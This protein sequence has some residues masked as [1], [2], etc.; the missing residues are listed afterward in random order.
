[1]SQLE[2]VLTG[3]LPKQRWYAAKGGVL[4]TVRAEKVTT[5]REGDPRLDLYVVE[6]QGDRYQVPLSFRREQSEPL[7]YALVGEVGGW[8]CY[9]APHDA[10]V[11]A[12]W[13]RLIGER[14]TVGGVTFDGEIADGDMPG[15]PMGAEQSNTSL[16]YGDTYI[17][18]LYRRLTDAPNPDL[19]IARALSAIGSTAIAPAL[20]WVEGAGSTLALLQPFMKGATDGWA[21]ALTSVRDL[22][23]ERDLHAEEVGGDFAPEACRLGAL[24]ATLHDD[25]ARALPSRLSTPEENAATAE[26]VRARL[27]AAAD[28]VPELRPYADGIEAVYDGVAGAGP[29]RVQRIHGDLHLGQCLRTGD[30]WLILDFE[31][32]PARPLAERTTLMSPLR[33][34]AGMLR[35]LDYAARYELA[36]RPESGQLGYRAV[37]WADRNRD[38]F[39][40]GYAQASGSDPRDEAVLL[41]AFELDKAVYEVRYEMAHRPSWVSIPLSGIERLVGQPR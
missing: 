8:F 25:L 17:L 12:T 26:L 9:D 2:D 24:T 35:S 28:A 11:N 5:L 39:C 16:V 29:V 41:R 33:D 21:L 36:G 38:A 10:A 4:R 34:V 31:G 3:W 14:A 23:A 40:D 27:A 7:A 1:V 30:G 20:G 18:K 15:R 22:Y 19:E 37:E 6:T 32:E 13:L